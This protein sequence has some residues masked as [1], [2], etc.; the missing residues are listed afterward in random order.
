VLDFNKNF[1]ENLAYYGRARKYS[2]EKITLKVSHSN[3]VNT[4]K[5]AVSPR[6]SITSGGLVKLT[7]EE[8]ENPTRLAQIEEESRRL[9][10]RRNAYLIELAQNQS[11]DELPTQTDPVKK[12][13]NRRKNTKQVQSVAPSPAEQAK[14]LLHRQAGAKIDAYFYQM[15]KNY[16]KQGALFLLSD[17]ILYPYQTETA[18]VWNINCQARARTGLTAETLKASTFSCGHWT[19]DL[20]QNTVTPVDK[21]AQMI[22]EE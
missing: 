17:R 18:G 19:T 9:Q 2:P 8:V 4:T 15:D 1:D 12:K 11:A 10:A 14:A 16:K 7:Y 22:W 13:K 21:R 3:L 20:N 5:V 6:G